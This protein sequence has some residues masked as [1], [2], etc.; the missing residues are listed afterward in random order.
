MF[1]W[2]G[3]P[4]MPPKT[5][6]NSK[7]D[8]AEKP[9]CSLF[10]GVQITL[11]ASRSSASMQSPL[12][13]GRRRFRAVRC[14][15][16]GFTTTAHPETDWHVNNIRSAKHMFSR[17]SLEEP[18]RMAGVVGDSGNG[19]RPFRP[20]LSKVE[21]RPLMLRRLYSQSRS[22]TD[23]QRDF[24]TGLETHLRRLTSLHQVPFLA[25]ISPNLVN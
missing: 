18:G 3:M 22:I 14:V 1:R 9:L 20:D 15:Y 10:P 23:Y 2:R 21:T 12:R 8:S 11:P 13:S 5:G 25:K 4:G 6:Q 7:F 24:W 17:I 19:E 16:F